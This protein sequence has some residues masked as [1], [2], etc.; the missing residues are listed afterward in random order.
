MITAITGCITGIVSLIL[1][2]LTR[3]EKPKYKIFVSK[4]TPKLPSEIKIADNGNICITDKDIEISTESNMDN[5]MNQLNEKYS[6]YLQLETHIINLSKN[7]QLLLSSR[8]NRFIQGICSSMHC[9]VNQNC[10]TL[11]KAL[12]PQTEICLILNY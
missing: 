12:T 5:L 7:T 11:P 8:Y 4:I 6:I 10:I 9:E 3:F 2:L 1:N